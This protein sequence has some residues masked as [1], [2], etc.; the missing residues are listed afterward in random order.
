MPK[1]TFL[2]LFSDENIIKVRDNTAQFL[3]GVLL[4]QLLL[5]SAG[6]VVQ[7][8]VISRDN[9]YLIAGAILFIL[10]LIYGQIKS[11]V[12]NKSL[13]KLASVVPDDVA[14]LVHK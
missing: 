3:G 11:Y 14:I 4:R 9:I 13:K 2:T 7:L 12:S 5:F 6:W 8:G 1:K 10:V